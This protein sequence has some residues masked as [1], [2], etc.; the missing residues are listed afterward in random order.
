MLNKIHKPRIAVL[1]GGLSDEY[2]LS[3]TNGNEIKSVL[4]ATGKYD[5][6]DVTV[7]KAGDWLIDGHVRTPE[8]I[9]QQVD[10][11]YIALHGKYGEDGTVQRQ[12]ERLG[13]PYLGSKPYQSSIG[14]HKMLTKEQLRELGI[15]LP[16]HMR[17]TKAG[18]TDLD[19]TS[20]TVGQLFGPEYVLKPMQGGSSIGNT[21]A[22]GT[23]GLRHALA[24]MFE[25]YDDVLIEEFITG[26][27]V[28]VG[29][30]DD[31][32][33]QKRYLTPVVEVLLEPGGGDIF[34]AQKQAP[35]ALT[36]AARNELL[37]LTELVHNTLGLTD[38]SR[39][40]FIVTA[41]DEVYFLEVNTLPA[42]T[43]NSPL[44]V[45]LESVGG[46]QEEL[47]CHLCGNQILPN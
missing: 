27:S 25:H 28:T 33:Q 43:K 31:F 11:V 14:M 21:R 46:T 19:A 3:V 4:S 18:V 26:K 15:K 32:R 8:H 13:V 10:G 40:D 5:L 45:A 24:K 7:T 42:V 36:K 2:Q 41:K 9:L 22:S 35:A 16:A 12:I 17:A 44:V 37:E 34:A 39:S 20:Q 47:I 23:A 1:K 6:L 38:M 29:C 30:L